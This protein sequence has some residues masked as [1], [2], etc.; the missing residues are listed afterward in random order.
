MTY[1]GTIKSFSPD[2]GYGFIKPDNR[3]QDVFIYISAFQTIGLDNIN[4]NQKVEYEI[5]EE[6]GKKSACNIKLV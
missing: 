3:K 1:S 4:Y 6:R 5:V 2:E